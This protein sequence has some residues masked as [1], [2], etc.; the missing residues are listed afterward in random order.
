MATA[1]EVTKRLLY[2]NAHNRYDS[3]E[4][5][6][7]DCKFL[8]FTEFLDEI[9][10]FKNP[11]IARSKGLFK[12]GKWSL[13]GY[14][15]NSFKQINEDEVIDEDDEDYSEQTFKKSYDIKFQ[16]TIFNGFFSDDTEVLQ[17]KKLDVDK[18]INETI[19]FL[20]KTFSENYI[21]DVSE[22]RDLQ[23][24]ILKY[25]KEGNLDRLEVCIL[26][27]NTIDQDK[28]PSKIQ[29]KNTDIECRI[30]YWDLKRWN[31]L[32][33]S[34]SKREA[35]N[36]DFNS[37]DFEHYKIPYLT[38]ETGEGL[39]Y[40]LSI[41]P[42]DLIADLYD[43]HNTS[44]LENN[45]RVFLS[46]TVKANKGIRE[47]IGGNEG[48]DAHK[49]FSYN[50]GLSATAESIKIIDNK[51]S[52]IKDF[53]IVNGGQTT[54]AIH[55][56]RKRDRYS[57]K[58]VHVAVKITGLQKNE[59]YSII[60]NKISQAAN[61]QSAV[62]VSDFYA[63][64]KMLVDIE[65]LSLKN[66]IQTDTDRNIYYFFE[67]MKGQY[68][69]SKLSSGTG[70]PQ[71]RWEKL[72]PKLLK[73][74]KIDI[75]RWYNLANELPHTAATGAQKQFHEFMNNKNFQ[76][77]DVNFSKYQTLIGVGLLFK[78]IK[79]LCGTSNGKVYPSLT[80]DPITKSHAPVAMSTA[81]YT[82]AYIH[83]VTNGC[84]DYWG[85]YNY[86]YSLTK[87]INN[88]TRIDSDIDFLLEKVIKICWLQIAT[89]GGAA[90]QEKTKSIECWNYVKSNI[91]L[92]DNILNE[93]KKYSV[94]EKVKLDRASIVQ[95][96]DDLD[97]FMN[98]HL[99]LNN[100][101]A[102]LQELLNIANTNTE[103]FSEK[104]TISNFVKKI[105]GNSLL[106]V[107]R[108]EEII[109]FHKMLIEQGF[110]FEENNCSII[111][112]NLEINIVYET[113]FKNKTVFLEKLYNSCFEI[114]E[115]F[116]ENEKLYNNIKEIIDKYYRE[117]GLSIDDFTL[118]EKG[119]I[120]I[121]SVN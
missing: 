41:F 1:L 5:A 26:S 99:L 63:N 86:K 101:G 3:D 71:K 47:T 8:N 88:N 80:I 69:V 103:Y 111:D 59:E 94:S 38:K 50:N 18:S 35:I 72:Y 82:T 43:L 10:V 61:T 114:E 12:K 15:I 57:L 42:G 91:S 13:L 115:L 14:S 105:N 68:N 78:R 113:I 110:S 30:K 11:T 23:K 6:I 4:I 44:L 31:D 32:K 56:S 37:I 120:A 19:R 52:N 34:K 65:K 109:S 81:L 60:V 96:N 112:L 39:T 54:A 89:F 121:E 85:F 73:F 87:A 64:D 45:V 108:I 40:Y 27:D 77:E 62:N 21:N 9:D 17:L 117:Y 29:L 51:I 84:L 24:Q 97:Y 106:P 49:F 100:R 22:A 76:R 20:E 118:L 7:E 28:L 107:K 46:S 67:R 92:P 79:K 104:K 98:L 93:F 83:K 2:T 25:H 16:Y 33:R 53:Q 102:I 36:I 119:L 75:A 70:S 58:D 66:P 95:N 48:K 90:A 116:D 55:H 74:D